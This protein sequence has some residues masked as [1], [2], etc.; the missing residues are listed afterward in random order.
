[1]THDKKSKIIIALKKSRTSIDKILDNMEHADQETC[2]DVIQQN[3]AVIGLLKSVNVLML[4]NHLNAYINAMNEPSRLQKKKM[5]Q[6]RDEVVRI[7]K[8]AQNK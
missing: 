2:F 8:T 3:L 5:E 1:M 7:I 4:E 6:V